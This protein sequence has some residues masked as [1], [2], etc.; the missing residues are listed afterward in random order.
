MSKPFLNEMFLARLDE[1]ILE[2]EK[3]WEAQRSH[4]KHK[5]M[6]I[7]GFTQWATSSLNLPD[8]LSVSTNR[9]VKQFEVQ[10]CGGPG[11][12]MNS[13]AALGVLKSARDEYACGLA[14]EYHLSVSAVVFGGLLDEAS[15]LLSKRYTRAAAVL[16]GAALEEGL[17]ARARASSV[18]VGPKDTLFPVIVKLKA[19]DVGAI[20]E[21]EAKRLEAIARLRN[22]AAHGGEFVYTDGD[23]GAAIKEVQ[24][25]LNK[26]LGSA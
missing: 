26:L 15:Y 14:V 7:V 5:I 11:H 4:E 22:D 16:L 1:L 25:V 3:Q 19:P 10:V 6:D 9:F 21:F 24:V 12:L 18:D 2:G 13:G 8:K 23:V 17:K 20:T